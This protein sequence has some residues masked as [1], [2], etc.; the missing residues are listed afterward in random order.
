VIDFFR[1]IQG[2]YFQRALE[3]LRSSANLIPSDLT[4]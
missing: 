2:I 4:R 3:L 1:S